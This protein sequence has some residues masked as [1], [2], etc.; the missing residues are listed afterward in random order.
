MEVVKGIGKILKTD[1]SAV[2]DGYGDGS[3]GL[4]YCRVDSFGTVDHTAVA[5][6]LLHLMDTTKTA[7]GFTQI[8]CLIVRN[9][10]CAIDAL[11]L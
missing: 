2:A 7:D 11:G 10:A 5:I 8:S 4:H 9:E 6:K 1:L 3:Y